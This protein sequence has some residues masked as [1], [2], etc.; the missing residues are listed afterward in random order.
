MSNTTSPKARELTVSR[1]ASKLIGSEIIKLAAEIN[2]KI[3]NGETVFNLTI[4]DFNPKI[5]PIPDGLKKE[6]IEAYNNN[7]TNYPAADGVLELRKAVSNLIEKRQGLKYEPNEI[8]IAGGARP[9]IYAIYRTL[10][11]PG[12]KIL[13][14]VP[15]WNNNHYTHLSTGDYA[16]EVLVET[17]PE[18]NFMPTAKEL[19]PHLSKVAMVAVCSPLNPT[20]TTFTKKDLEEICD[21]ILAENERR[22]PNEKPLYLLYDQIYWALTY[23]EVKHY[24]P[25]SLRPEMRNYTIF[26]DGISK[27]LASTGVRVGWAMG[28]KTIIDNMK[29][30][31]S[32][33][34][35]WAPKAEQVATA[36]FLSN[37]DQYDAFITDIRKKINERLVGFHNGFQSLKKKGYHVNSIAPQAAIYLTVQFSL[38]GQ[39]TADGKILETTKDVTKYILDE[40][41]IAV[42][43]FYAFGSST[44]SN[45]Y[46]L[47]VGTCKLEDVNA[48][49]ESLDKA[50]AKL[51]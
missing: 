14:P 4:G 10:I 19:A 6:I 29:S 11:D 45:W 30:I 25:V 2:E 1:M 50:L 26:V 37:L 28:P 18:N 23:G 46:R 49:I 12:D 48:I 32:H 9:I 16:Q 51:S 3:K 33:V 13:F 17:S 24:D 36:K 43:P 7:E 8:L 41:K 15:S 35:A 21:L 42:V 39:K 47:S 5:F 22:G 34:G 40:A 20:G 31:L 44:D 38:H 27:S